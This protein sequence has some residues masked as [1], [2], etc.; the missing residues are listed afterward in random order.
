MTII[1]I[2]IIIVIRHKQ[3]KPL[4]LQWAWL[5]ETVHRTLD[6]SL[7]L[8]SHAVSS[9]QPSSKGS[10][11]VD[12]GSSSIISPH[13]DTAIWRTDITDILMRRPEDSSQRKLNWLTQVSSIEMEL[14]QNRHTVFNMQVLPFLFYFS[15][16]F[17]YFFYFTTLLSHWD[18]SHGKFG[19]PSLW[20]ASC[21]SCTIQLQQLC[22]SAHT[23]CFNKFF[24]FFFS[25]SIIHW[26]LTGTTDLQHT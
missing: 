24:F 23:A 22:C 2:I 18:F 12:N 7:K 1:I 17:C 25:V 20:K 9:L 11:Q 8:Q 26:N 13:T 3:G 14:R 16:L 21:S 4:Y 6:S 10:M 15:F 5:S 19:S